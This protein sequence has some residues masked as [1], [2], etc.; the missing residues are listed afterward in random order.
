MAM[1]NVWGLLLIVVFLG[2]GLV[3]VPRDLWRRSDYHSHL[4]SLQYRAPGMK[5]AA[6]D[7]EIELFE[8]ASDVVAVGRRIEEGDPLRSKVDRILAKCPQ[9][10]LSD[11]AL[12]NA[13]RTSSIPSAG[14]T[15][16]YIVALHVRL[17]AA[18]RARDRRE[19]QWNNLLREAF[20]L[21]DMVESERNPERMLVISAAK[22]G[23][24]AGWRMSFGEDDVESTPDLSFVD[25]TYT[26]F[27]SFRCSIILFSISRR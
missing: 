9:E 7:A 24:V 3:E 13:G 20:F 12:A 6:N 23:D 5:E 18:V 21:E 14:I 26:N 8:V 1:A 16:A 15:D 17:K 4:R 11:R 19:A 22:G 10:T 2:H 25:L 27:H